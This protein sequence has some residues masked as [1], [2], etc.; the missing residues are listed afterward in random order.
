MHKTILDIQKM[1]ARGER[2]PMVTAYDYTSAQ[3]VDRAG[4]PIILVGDSLGMVVLGHPTTIPVTVDEIIHHARAV[5]RGSQQALVIGD[6]PFLSYTTVEQAVRTAGRLLQEAGVRAVKLE[7]G[8]SVA[9]TVR[10]LVEVGIPVMAHIG[11]TPQSENQLGRRVQGKHADDALRL[12]EDALALEQA[13]AFAL[14]LE[15]VPAE[16]AREITARLHIPTIGIGAGPWCDGQVQ[17]WHDL[18]GA[19]TDFVPRHARRY[20]TLADTIAA[21]LQSYAD[22][23][24]AG[25]FPTLEHGSTMKEQDLQEALSQVEQR[26][27]GQP[28]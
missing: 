21:A 8:A 14:V 5:V 28:A 24:R 22:D 11:Y 4:I 20:A 2:I 19:Y 16:L 27:N 1:K 13:G 18:L 25:A 10:R 26:K 17:I 9:P 15:L 3:A 6:M 7:G 23:V 12:I